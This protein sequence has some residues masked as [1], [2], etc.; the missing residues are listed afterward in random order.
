MTATSHNGLSYTTM[1]VDMSQ[2]RWEWHQL[3]SD[4][5][6]APFF[7]AP[8]EI[9]LLRRH[10]FSS[11]HS[12][13]L[14][15]R[16]GWHI[17]RSSCW[18][19]FSFFCLLLSSFRFAMHQVQCHIQ[20]PFTPTTV[21]SVWFF[22]RWLISN[23]SQKQTNTHTHTLFRWPWPGVCVYVYAAS[24]NGFAFRIFMLILFPLYLHAHCF[25]PIGRSG[26]SF[27]LS[28]AVC[29]FG[30]PSVSQRSMFNICLDI[31]VQ[32][33][34][35]VSI[36]CFF[37]RW[38]SSPYSLFVLLFVEF[39][40]C[41]LF[42]SVFGVPRRF[43]PDVVWMNV[44]WSSS[45]SSSSSTMPLHV[46]CAHKSVSLCA[47]FVRCSC[48]RRKFHATNNN[49]QMVDDVFASFAS[50]CK[51]RT[52]FASYMLPA[53][54]SVSRLYEWIFEFR[55]GGLPHSVD[56]IIS[57]LLDFFSLASDQTSFNVW[58]GFF[59]PY[60]VTL[61]SQTEIAVNAMH[62]YVLT[63]GRFSFVYVSSGRFFHSMMN[64]KKTRKKRREERV[65][66]MAKSVGTEKRKKK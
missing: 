10:T 39:C 21:D 53:F 47:F 52:P 20:L 24:K 58:C 60:A 38:S 42:G 57:L 3:H 16:R 66:Q 49:Q 28:V 11:S 27:F 34:F 54:H 15:A 46:N 7:S 30:A 33:F 35:C 56:M 59:R 63:I 32:Q 1:N 22:G 64:H 12:N 29:Q 48:S 4:T 13:L 17:N 44:W 19:I 8:R 26:V 50:H 36:L 65:R 41:F 6:D 14:F 62:R 23:I 25:S 37:F 9:V 43:L 31:V 40:V 55:S 5:D 51:S 61:Q 2:V 18:I 45:S